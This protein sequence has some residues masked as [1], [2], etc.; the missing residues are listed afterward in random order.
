MIDI[1]VINFNRPAETRLCL[2]AIKKFALF[3]NR[4][5]LFNNGGN[6]P[7]EIFRSYQEG[8][9][10][11]LVINKIN[12]GEGFGC[13]ELYNNCKSK[14]SFFI[15]NDC[16]L[17][18]PITQDNINSFIYTLEY[19][20]ASCID[21]TGGICGENT[22]SGRVFFMN[23]EFYKSIKKCDENGI[24]GGPGPYSDVP[25][26]ENFIQKYFKE[27]NLKVAH[28]SKIYKE[29]G[30]YAVRENKDGSQYIHRCDTQQL[31]V[32]VY[33]TERAAHPPWNDEEWKDVLEKK[34]W[35]AWKI[36]TNDKKNSFV[37][38][39][40]PEVEEESI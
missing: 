24:Y 13:I 3:E 28:T 39:K 38:F 19:G 4:V 17:L 33:P 26:L 1:L 7:A 5:I 20:G 32:L 35:P 8:L 10:D 14:Y 25:P 6:D 40:E 11:K 12:E 23:T 2:E 34:Y 21:L 16:E 30:C 22:Y 29:N 37:H 9:I 27:N 31:K 15:E 36:P 18:Y